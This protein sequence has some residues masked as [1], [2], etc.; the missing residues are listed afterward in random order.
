MCAWG[1]DQ[2]VDEISRAANTINNGFETFHAMSGK[3]PK[4]LIEESVERWYVEGKKDYE[5]CINIIE[6]ISKKYQKTAI[7]HLNYIHRYGLIH[8]KK[9]P[10]KVE[11]KQ[12]KKVKSRNSPFYWSNG[13]ND[14]MFLGEFE[15][16]FTILKYIIGFLIFYGIVLLIE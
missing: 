4:Q 10:Q 13:D 1:V 5:Y 12:K 7:N 9:K 16:P 15:S 3:Y 11:I 2:M 8:L 6:Y 14:E